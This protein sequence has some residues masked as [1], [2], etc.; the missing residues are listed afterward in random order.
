MEKINKENFNDS[1]TKFVFDEGIKRSEDYYNNGADVYSKE[2]AMVRAIWEIEKHILDNMASEEKDVLFNYLTE[3][4]IE[5]E[6]DGRNSEGLLDMLY[7][8]DRDRAQ[9]FE[10]YIKTLPD[11][12]LDNMDNIKSR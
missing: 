11:D 6:N 9:K 7:N 8:V 12:V 5:F 3:K 4:V 2:K 10:D 1:L